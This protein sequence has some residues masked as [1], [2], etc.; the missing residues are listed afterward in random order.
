MSLSQIVC[1]GEFVRSCISCNDVFMFKS[2][3]GISTV[4]NASQSLCLLVY[5][6]YCFTENQLLIWSL[7]IS[8]YTSFMIMKTC[9]VT[10][11]WVQQLLEDFSHFG[12]SECLHQGWCWE[13]DSGDEDDQLRGSALTLRS[14]NRRWRSLF[15][16]SLFPFK[17]LMFPVQCT[18][19]MSCIEI[20]IYSWFHIP[21]KRQFIMTLPHIYQLQHVFFMT[22][23]AQVWSSTNS[24]LI[25][26][27]LSPCFKKNFD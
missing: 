20:V 11:H 27:P 15:G 19:D 8:L 16:D 1:I 12:D 6:P 9:F 7:L 21:T 22:V 24:P 2:L 17:P 26:V 4:W 25:S 14:A 10:F 13:M 3:H 18:N 5:R 23:E